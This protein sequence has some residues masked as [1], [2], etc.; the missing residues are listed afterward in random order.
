MADEKSV[1]FF[2]STKSNPPHKFPFDNKVTFS[3]RLFD[4]TER[5]SSGRVKV[6]DN[7]Y[8]EV[9]MSIQESV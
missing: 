4:K 7:K 8:T 2:W 3:M 6:K 9:S 1:K 5:N